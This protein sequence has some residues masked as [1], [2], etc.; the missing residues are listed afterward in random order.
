VS[1]DLEGGQ[2]MSDPSAKPASAPQAK[3]TEAEAGQV[4]ELRTYIALPGKWDELL[5]QFREHLVKIFADHNI[6]CHGFWKDH[7]RE[8]ALVY[9]ASHFGNPE[10][11]WNA[12]RA[13]PRWAAIRQASSTGDQ[14]ISSYESRFLTP[15]DIEVVH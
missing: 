15:V 1:L 5:T 12:F 2:M 10:D 3:F 9:L 4:Y 14:I 13:D 8:D 11:N 6:R 7:E